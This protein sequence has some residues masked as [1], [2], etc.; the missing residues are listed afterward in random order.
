[1]SILAFDQGTTSS[2]AILFDDKFN[3]VKSASYP[4]EQIYPEAGY[5]EH[6]PEELYISILR[7]AADCLYGI[8]EKPQA[9]GIT[10]QRETVI[11]WDKASGKPLHNAIVW[12]CRRTAPFCEELK[13]K[14]YE[15]TIKQKTG[16]PIDAY[17]SASKIKWILDHVD[18]AEEKCAR[19]ELLAGT[20]DTWLIWRLTGNHYTDI[21]NASRTMLFD[22]TKGKWDKELCELFEIPESMLPEVKPSSYHFG[23]VKKDND[24]PAVLWELPI[25]SAIGDQQSALFGQKC[26]TVGNVKNTYGTG[27]FTLMN[28]GS[29]PIFDENLITTPA[30]QFDGKTSYALEGSVFNAGSSVQWLRDSL[31]IIQTTAECSALAETVPSTEGVTFVSAFTGL[32]APHWDMYARA[33]F[34]GITRG[35]GRAHLCRAVLEGIAFQVQELVSAMEEASGKTISSLKVDGGASANR[36]LMQFQA[37]LLGISVFRPENIETTALGA[38]Y[39]AAIACGIFTPETLLEA[40]TASTVF[41]PKEDRAT[42]EKRMARWQKAVKAIR[43][44]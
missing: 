17:F 18:G 33:G 20:V 38:A 14:G 29:E 2:R 23:K 11:V 8:A 9:I 44:Y 12:Q 30:W 4:I 26:L 3:I 10:N 40:P 28:I 7:S 27:C 19:G 41:T 15:K 39:M 24:I 6:N 31:G 37:D 36:F 35:T 43:L 13:A 21:T 1:M 5:V 34:V 22:I 25:L 32:G 42:A 16:L